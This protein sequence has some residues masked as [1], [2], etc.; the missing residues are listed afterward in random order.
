MKIA[1]K[2]TIIYSLIL[3]IIIS[4]LSFY[5]YFNT[6]TIL[7][8]EHRKDL[9]I[10]GFGMGRG[11][12]MGR[13]MGGRISSFYI[14]TN[15]EIIQDPFNLGKVEKEGIYKSSDGSYVLIVKR[16]SLF[17]GKDITSTL[18][19]LDRLQN[20][21]ILISILSIIPSTF[22]SYFLSQKILYPIRKLIKDAKNIDIRDSNSRVEVPKT[23]DE[24][25]ELANTINTMLERIERL[26]K[27]EEEFSSDISH[28]LKTPLTSILGY[29]KMLKRW[30]KEDKKILN[31]SLDI[32]EETTQNMVNMV[33]TLLEMAKTPE[34]INYEEF[35]IKDFLEEL[36]E[37]V[38]NLYPE[39]QFNVYLDKERNLFTSR[40]ALGIIM[41]IL[42]ENGVKN[43]LDKKV[44][45][46]GYQN[47]KLFVKDYGMGIPKEEI[48]KIFERFYK[49]DRSRSSKGYGL[50]LSLAK[51][52]AESLGFEILVESKEGEGSTFYLQ[53]KSV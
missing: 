11:F 8:D 13:M 15:T 29:I 22:I 2:L 27:R 3:T 5:Y 34:N 38:L 12:M 48:P 7:I 21:S 41:S 45:D 26:Y 43:S 19:A 53:R 51:K 44:I 36:R 17:I 50:G 18:Y 39:F 37:K 10:S 31:E 4:F 9:Y 1:W 24:L 52:L 40:K 32:L 16:D 46:L 20:I 14:A 35:S 23:R 47:G 49:V 25:W 30:G 33:D 6:K 28:E 42:L